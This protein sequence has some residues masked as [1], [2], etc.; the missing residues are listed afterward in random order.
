MTSARIRGIYTTALT[1]TLSAAGVT[2][3]QPS[4][5]IRDRFDAVFETAPADALVETSRCSG[6]VEVSGDPEAVEQV[7]SIL[8]SVAVDAFRWDDPVA[9]GAVFDATVGEASGGSGAVVD[10]GG[11]ERGYLRYDDVDGYV[12]EGERYRVQVSEPAPPWSDDDPLV[13]PT[14]S[15]ERGLL[16]LSPERT[17]VSAA[18]RGERAR[19]VV[20]MTDLLSPTPPDG[21]GIR[22]HESALESDLPTMGEALARA[23]EEAEALETATDGE[24]GE[25][26][27][28][29]APEATAWVWFGREARVALDEA[30]REVATT[31]AGH[32]RIKAATRAASAAVDFAEAVCDEPAA[33]AEAFPF[34][35]VSRQ[36]GPRQG[37]RLSLG[38]GKPDG[39]LITLGTG[40]VTDCDADGSLTLERE[41]RGGGTYDAL[42]VPIE[43]GDVAVTKL[44]EGR[45]WYATTYRDADGET[46][47]TYVNVCTP[48][49]L[50][51][52]CARYVDLYI[53]VVR[54]ADGTVDIVD[55]DELETAAEA[56]VLTPE[57]AEKAQT[58]AAALE[59]AFSTE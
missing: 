4:A 15:V 36:F 18:A 32:H 24:V 33:D 31:M 57:L 50:F 21:W 5:T 25:P 26:G 17:G 59:R 40:T 19:E 44:S 9:R 11:G 10:L 55:A 47:G 43:D 48:V 54:H 12:E 14:L 23:V 46:K 7:A 49:E 22:W 38:H 6:G 16:A 27:P 1:R 52:D 8:E 20:G 56:G 3:V 2:V 58:V 53:D 28:V 37:D 34:G 13:T 29:V 39:R 51:P 42:D 45:W 30:R 35:A 41:M